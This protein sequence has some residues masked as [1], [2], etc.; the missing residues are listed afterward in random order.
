MR[1]SR[2]LPVALGGLILIGAAVVIVIAV[3]NYDGRTAAQITRGEP[4]EAP[5]SLK[6]CPKEEPGNTEEEHDPGIEGE[7]VPPGPDSALLCGWT[8]GKV[9][10]DRFKLIL[11]E[12][13]LRRRSDLGKLA[14]ALNSLPPITP[15]P[16]G[17]YACP[18]AENFYILV[19]LRYSGS[20]E[21]EVG[22]GPGFCGGITALNLQGEKEYG[23]STK[24]L[25]LLD[26]LLGKE[27]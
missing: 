8:Y 5:S 26:A 27:S 9:R 1:P 15:F 20:S 25:D 3:S 18:E 17:T 13:V 24:L 11:S 21:V 4:G 2:F 23:A 7:T 10:A 14:D 19:G 22:I 6:H 12:K 16:E